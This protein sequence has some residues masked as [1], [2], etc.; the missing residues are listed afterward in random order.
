M[1]KVFIGGLVMEIAVEV[2]N[3]TPNEGHPHLS[4]ERSTHFHGW[5]LPSKGPMKPQ[6]HPV[7][8]AIEKGFSAMTALRLTLAGLVLASLAACAQPPRVDETRTQ[9][10]VLD[11]KSELERGP[12]R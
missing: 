1:I 5:L 8:S 7:F 3:L 11:A 2:K 6:V 4:S 9:R 12:R 10:P